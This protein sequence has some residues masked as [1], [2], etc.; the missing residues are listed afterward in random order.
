MNESFQPA[1]RSW[2]WPTPGRLGDY[3]WSP[4]AWI[5]LGLFALAEFGNW[6]MGNEL[7]RVCELLHQGDFSISR[8][9]LVMEEVEAVCRNR[10]L[11]PSR[12]GGNARQRMQSFSAP[13]LSAGQGV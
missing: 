8:S 5:L 7:R 11:Q 10:T 12:D 2:L 1:R 6:Q 4:M 9:E 13:E 3:P